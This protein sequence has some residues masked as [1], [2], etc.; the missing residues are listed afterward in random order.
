VRLFSSS[1]KSA[2]RGSVL[3]VLAVLTPLSFT[4]CGSSAF[5]NPPTTKVALPPPVVAAT[6]SV[7]ASTDS[8]QTT[9]TKPPI[10]LFNGTGTSS[11]DVSA[12]ESILNTLKLG[13]STVNTSQMNSMSET[14]LKSYKL[15]IVPGGNSITIGKYLT[16]AATTN[17]H[18]A[19]NGGLH[20]LGICAGAFF[21]GYSI[22]NGLNLTGG[23]WFN[24]YSSN[25]SK[26]VVDILFPNGTVYDMYEQDGPE[27]AGWGS[28]VGK[29]S[30]GKPAIAEGKFGYGWVILSG[31]H[32][33]A[34]AS[35]RTGMDFTTSVA[36]D[37]AY[38]AK[39]VT[40][41]LNG[42]WLPHF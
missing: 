32:P 5:S 10:L 4:G 18:N 6:D 40:Y 8:V 13:Y 26:Q 39:L 21:G 3:I 20:Y 28:I 14:T 12:V 25:T 41:A 24:L 1:S 34:P 36:T 16:K 35:W 27:L 19:V 30:D 11:S 2:L 38:A 17:I 31:V 33:E 23:V 42:T 22:Y 15:L 37:Q 9:S 29:Y 7:V